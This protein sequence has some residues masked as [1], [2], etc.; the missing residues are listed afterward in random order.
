MSNAQHYDVIVIGGGASGMMAAGKAAENGRRVLLVEKNK[1]LGKKLSITGG[2]RCNIYNAEKD[3]RK[4]LAN[5]GDSAKFLHSAFAQHGMQDSHDF[6]VAQG[7]PIVVEARKR[8]FPESQDAR[9]VTATMK[10]YVT[11]NRVELRTG[12][13]VQ[14]FATENGKIVGIETNKGDFTADSYILATGG[15]AHAETGASGEG[16]EWL[17]ELGHTIHASNPNIVPLK[18]DEKWVKDLS[19]TTLS[20]MKITFG[21]NGKQGKPFSRTGKIL[22]THF[23]LSGPLILNAAHEVKKLLSHGPVHATI[24]LYPDTEVGT[25]R[26]RVL[27]VFNINKNKELRNVLKEFVPHGMTDA[28][29]AQ[30]DNELASMRVH[31]VSKEDRNA[32]VDRLK[33]MPLI[34]TGTMGMDWAVISDGGVDLT[35]ID[36]KTMR[37]KVHENLFFTGDVLHINRPSGGYS[38]QLCWTTGHVA[39]LNA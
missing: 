23:G 5:F 24:D 38:L 25:L 9:D 28:V 13:R 27:E 39:G 19:G 4:L 1:M 2:G 15:S 18:V 36:T 33:A 31:S 37:S 6:F 35:E 22:F 30:L 3:Q 26:N 21:V 32:L 14:K 10:K 34:V 7:L 11:D 12:T 20:F 17:S 16:I 8:A 29:A